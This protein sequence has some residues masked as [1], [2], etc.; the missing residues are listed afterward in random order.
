ML[1]SLILACKSPTPTPPVDTDTDVT[2]TAPPVPTAD[3]APEIP[4]V[5][6]RITP[7]APFNYEQLQTPRAFHGIAFDHEGR[8]V[9]HD[10]S[11]LL[12]SM[13]P[14]DTSIMVPNVG[15]T[16]QVEF[17]ES[18]D[19]IT[20]TNNGIRRYTPGAGSVTL[21]NGIN[22][23]G[24]TIG[25]DGMIYTA[26]TNVIHRID[27]DTGDVEVWHQFQIGS[28]KVLDF[29]VD[30]RTMYVGTLGNQ[31]RVYTIAVSED[32]EAE[33]A[34]ELFNNTPGGSWHDGLRVDACGRVYV[35]VYDNSALYMFEPDGTRTLLVNYPTPQYGHGIQWGSGVG[36]W[37][38]HTI[39]VPQPYDNNRVAKL[40]LGVPYRN[41]NGGVYEVI[42]D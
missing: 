10:G 7:A 14:D 11:N 39:Y 5:D 16:E 27:P 19:L 32:F 4:V 30:H 29:S 28:P 22:A 15:Y 2:D 3:T 33:G 36:E 17:L 24:V 18:G 12:V 25:S 8:M 23:Y 34:P 13:A 40:E 35:A 41:Y 9:G 20:A 42:T 38:D 26:N 37:D 6:C 1:I 31:G 21:A